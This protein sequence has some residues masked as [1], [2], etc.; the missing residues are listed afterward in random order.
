MRDGETGP[1]EIERVT[2]C[3]QMRLERKRT[4]PEA[5]LMVTRRP[6]SDTRAL[7]PQASPDATEQDA[8]SRSRYSLTPTGGAEGTF[9]EPSLGELARVIKAGACMAAR[10]TRGKGEVG[11]D[12]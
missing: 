5:W 7:E 8:R 10:F 12:A 6:L 11:M 4:R 3:V 2:R 9:K 1:V